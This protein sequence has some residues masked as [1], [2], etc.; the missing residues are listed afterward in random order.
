MTEPDI[1]KE[2]ARKWYQ[3][4]FWLIGLGILA[5]GSVSDSASVGRFL[6]LIFII[7]GILFLLWLYSA[8]KTTHKFFAFIISLFITIILSIVLFLLFNWVKFGDSYFSSTN[9][10]SA[11]TS[12][13][14]AKKG[15]DKY[16]GLR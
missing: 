6:I 14:S 11:T 12:S 13:S 7:T 8:I 15:L 2:S 9:T 10:T 16:P 1:I 5:L 3:K 4:P